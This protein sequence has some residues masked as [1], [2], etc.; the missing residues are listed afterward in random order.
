V[1]FFRDTDV[2]IHYDSSYY[3]IRVM[4]ISFNQTFKQRGFKQKTLHNAGA[5][6]EASEIN[7]ANPAKF[8]MQILMVD[9]NPRYQ[10]KPIELL[11]TNSGDTLQTFDLYIDPSTAS[12]SPRKMYK[13]STCVFESGAFE[14]A[15]NTVMSVSF[16]GSGSKLERV[17]YSAFSHNQ[18][19][20]PTYA[21]PSVMK[22]TVDGTVLED[23][24]RVGLE[25]QN[26]ITWTKNN[27]IQNALSVTGAT[28]STYPSSFVLNGREVAGNITTYI[29]SQDSDLQ[30]W[31]ENIAIRIETGIAAS[32]YQLD[33]NL[34]PCSFTNRV[35]PTEIYT[36][37]YDFRMIGTPTNL[38]TLFTY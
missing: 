27:T 10:H 7:E 36:Q 32:N 31:K 19:S 5:L 24:L 13:I 30:A 1:Q 38:N 34:T 25:V 28:N 9:E 29:G 8:D 35:N 6:V 15:K 14:I 37:G 22:A 12:D 20:G 21:R 3:K 33:A 4:N 17:N 26:K 16:S 18:P 11:L 2:Y 23:V